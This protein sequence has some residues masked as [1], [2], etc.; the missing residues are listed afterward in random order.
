MAEE[1][2]LKTVYDNLLVKIV[3]LLQLL[4]QDSD[5]D[6][7]ER[8]RCDAITRLDGIKNEVTGNI[9]SL[10]E[11][12]EWDKFTVAFYGETNAGKSTLIECLR[13][14]LNEKKKIDDHKHFKNKQ[15]ELDE[16][17][18]KIKDLESNIP[19][20]EDK[21]NQSKVEFQTR[22]SRLQHQNQKDSS[23]KQE[24]ISAIE[25]QIKEL[26]EQEEVLS[27]ELISLYTKKNELDKIVLGKIATSTWELIK[28]W[29]HNL[30]EQ[31]E[32]DNINSKIVKLESEFD[33]A[34]S[35]IER[36]K[37]EIVELNQK[38]ETIIKKYNGEK[39]S[40]EKNIV[41]L[42]HYEK[43]QLDEINTQ[44]N[45]AKELQTNMISELEELSDGSII[46]DGRSDFTQEVGSYEF[47]VGDKE[48]VLLDL[49][50]IEGKEEIVQSSIKNAIE[51]AHAIFY[52]SKKSTPPQ[53]GDDKNLG[54]IEKI[55]KQ[56]SKHS[57]VYFIYNKPVRNPRQLKNPLID[58]SEK[59]SLIVVDK[60]L[61]AILA[62]NYISHQSLSAYPAF[63]SVGNFYGDKY[64]KDRNKFIEK[65]GKL[66]N[67]LELSQVKEF[68]NWMTEQ[69]VN[70]VKNKIIQSNFKKISKTLDW[71]VTEIREISSFFKKLEEKLSLNY[72]LTSQK[73]DSAADVFIKNLFSSGRKAVNS[74]KNNIRKNI[75]D[76]IGP[77]KEKN[78]GISDEDFKNKLEQ[79]IKDEIDTFTDQLNKEIDKKSKEFE[80]EVLEIVSTYQRYVDQLVEQHINS[81]K[82]D[83]EF[84]PNI[85]INKNKT[86]KGLIG[87]LVID[88]IGLGLT[89]LTPAAW[90]IIVL[91]VLGTVF[92]IGKKI[93]TFR[94]KDF[95]KS[96]QRKNA[97]KNI[98]KVVETI[99]KE[100]NKQ[101]SE[102]KD[103][104]YK[105][106][107]KIKNTL[108][109]PVV[110][111][112]T[113]SETFLDVKNEI[114]QLSFEIMSKGE[115]K[116]GNN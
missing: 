81:V 95:Q 83:F 3:D 56:L 17:S 48:F 92:S 45:S 7:V 110:Q 107:P 39:E 28:A 53:K 11:N 57:E 106:V 31:R 15:L 35:N 20:V 12:S 87:G 55:S 16:L 30:E 103:E 54:T 70:D 49:P 86:V 98:D 2:I 91:S 67:V 41:D 58:D 94:D 42:E 78:K 75:Y 51:K 108:Y 76:D 116:D 90:F 97:D 105:G 13:I 99:Q 10:E 37:E 5:N 25:V 61:S 27:A 64:S 18:Q 73:L 102:I 52:V 50:G 14:L 101:L 9:K 47:L 23:E 80:T 71:T 38:F 112:R 19:F 82:L 4:S 96:Q 109:E 32:S 46:G 21:F 74:L 34:Q 40:I 114:K 85:N 100:L 6:E 113:M 8:Y 44:I 59:E 1:N 104:I 60:E 88:V 72:K 79:Y 84:E 68:S 29:F 69:L 33:D 26:N 24:N 63:L 65:I 36:Y 77:N 111:V 115:N 22:L 89:F 62:E 43:R 93:H 66:N